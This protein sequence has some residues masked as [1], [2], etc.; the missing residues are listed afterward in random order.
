MHKYPTWRVYKHIPDVCPYTKEQTTEPRV[1]H[2]DWT[3]D[4]ALEAKALLERTDPEGYY[5]IEESFTWM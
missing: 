5:S 2:E 4:G 1:E 3:P